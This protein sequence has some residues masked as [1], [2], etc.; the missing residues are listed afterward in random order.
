MPDPNQVQT[1]GQLL[2]GAPPTGNMPLYSRP[3]QPPSL[4]GPQA[5]QPAQP[6]PQQADTARHHAIGRAASFL[7]GAQR[8]PETGE[9]IKQKPGT[10]FR[11]LL[12]GALLGGAIGSEGNAGGGSVGGFLGGFARGGNAVNQQ[13]QEQAQ[14]RQQLSLEEQKA[15]DEHTLHQAT[16]AHITAETAAFHHN[17]EFQDQEAVDRKNAAS[18]AYKQVL[19]DAG[20]R[21]APIAIDGKVPSNGEYQAPD[22]AAAYMRDNSILMGPP[23]TVRHFV[24][25]HS[26]SDIEYVPGKGWVNEAGDPAD[27]SKNTTVRAID[28]PENLYQRTIKHTGK[29]INVIAGYQLIPPDQEDSTFN[30]PL[31]SFAGLYVQHL[32]NANAEAQAKQRD[33]DAAKAKAQANKAATAKRGTPAQFKAVDV[34][35]DAEL[36]KAESDFKK[37]S[38]DLLGGGP[39]AAAAALEAAKARIEKGYQQQIKDLGGSI[40]PVGSQSGSA[41]AQPAVKPPSGTPPQKATVYDPQGQAHFVDGD[42]VHAFLADPKYK[43]WHQ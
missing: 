7:F 24:D 25:E 21:S 17:Q 33:A 16:T 32:K 31:N 30:A 40:A 5:P 23:G 12:A 13:A 1:P 14:K 2:A 43:G 22:L 42:K 19:L 26:A 38:K 27:M 8:D 41:P 3:G 39:K 20:G 4:P 9:P 11:S 36:K 29:E 10:L 34:W 15:Q 37:D 18:R 6:T 35:H 28:V